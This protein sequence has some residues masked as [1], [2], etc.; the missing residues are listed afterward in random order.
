[1]AK[2]AR[3]QGVR[4]SDRRRTCLQWYLDHENIPSPEGR[5]HDAEKY[6]FTG[7]EMNWALENDLLCVG[8]N[9]WHVP[10]DAGRT[11]LASH[12]KGD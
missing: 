1:M 11:A 3:Q 9:G 7:R 2:I 6:P 12:L 8:P 5:F 10:S 4:L